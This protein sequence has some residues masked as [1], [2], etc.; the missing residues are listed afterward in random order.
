MFLAATPALLPA[1]QDASDSPP[2]SAPTMNSRTAATSSSA[3]T[4]P[5]GSPLGPSTN[6][7][8]ATSAEP[9]NA[10]AEALAFSDEA[11]RATFVLSNA[12]P[13]LAAV[14]ADNWRGFEN[15][16]RAAAANAE[17]LYVVTGPILTG[18]PTEFSGEVAVPNAPIR[19]QSVN[20][21]GVS[22]DE[23]E[24]RTGLDLFN[25]PRRLRGAPPRVGDRAYARANP[26]PDLPDFASRGLTVTAESTKFLLRFQHRRR[27]APQ[28]P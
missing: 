3:T 24:R 11:M 7:L 21:F 4:P 17:A 20:Q 10:P 6:S 1:H 27:A 2:A 28:I 16:V 5:A 8:P 12:A 15:A 26:Y 18:T 22:A 9:R 19:A 14:N 23:V 25:R 13:R